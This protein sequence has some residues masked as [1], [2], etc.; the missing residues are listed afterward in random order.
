MD[1]ILYLAGVAFGLFLLVFV[2]YTIF[3]VV[4]GGAL[5][6]GSWIGRRLGLVDRDDD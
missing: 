3:V 1:T 2:P 6:I 4:V 5:T